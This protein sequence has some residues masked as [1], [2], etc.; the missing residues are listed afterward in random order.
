[1]DWVSVLLAAVCGAMAA[2]VASLVTIKVKNNRA[3]Y[4]VITLVV[5][6]GLKAFSNK[7]ILP[8][9][10]DWQ[11]DRQ[12]RELPFYR[13]LAE[14]DPQTYQKI[15][16]VASDSVRKGDGADVIAS[17]MVPIVAGTV[18]KY[19]GT[20]SD[21]SVVAYIDV[22]VQQIEALHKSHSD[23]CY[24]LLFPREQGAMPGVISS[25]DQ[26]TRDESLDTLGR[27]VHSAV[28][29]PQPLPDARK[30]EALLVPVMDQLRGEFGNDL[31][32]FQQKPTDSI[33]RQKVCAITVF[34]YKNVEALPQRDA[35]LLLRY[36]L[37][38]NKK[39]NSEK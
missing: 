13:D 14:V 22:I 24:Y 15:R 30:A 2:T 11:T 36:L 25:L 1:M 29:T 16:V 18:P 32:L 3:P 34:L 35:S 5:F 31:M 26:K 27:I 23:A 7:T 17:R 9:V 6:L 37:S 12:L 21:E 10:R 28:H 19:V 39:S 4:L 20:A 8:G 38:D 33:G